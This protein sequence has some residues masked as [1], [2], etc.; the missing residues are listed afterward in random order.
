MVL[1][2]KRNI[3]ACAALAAS[4]VVL[5]TSWVVGG[6]LCA[7]CPREIGPPP[8]DLPG[9]SVRFYS[10]S[11][12]TLHGW[13]I[14]S[15]TNRGVVILLHGIRASRLQMVAR[16]RFLS[17]AGYAVLLFD[18]QAEGESY[19]DHIAFGYLEKKDAAAA[20]NF[21]RCTLPGEKIGVI[22]LSLGG[23]AAVLAEPPLKVNALVLESV[24]PSL[25]EAVADRLIV[26]FGRSG[27]H[28]APLLTGQL[29][30]RLG[31]TADEL[32]PIDHV[33]DIETPKL[34]IAGTA[35]RLTTPAESLGLYLAAA[36][37]KQFWELDG[38]GH[39]DLHQFA[40][41]E[42][43]RRVLEFLAKNLR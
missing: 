15:E 8:A 27:K 23:A 16:A 17:Q 37:P 19:G 41:A 38:A 24:F 6:R 33:G 2:W 29:P 21:V 26:R 12:S 7:P 10:A 18:F 14:A 9:K 5:V 3:K 20:A 32:R 22:G 39:E 31:F 1:N 42:Y 11:G 13:L 30:L 43:E 35:D 25:T 4:L 40:P 34:F 36:A 28:L